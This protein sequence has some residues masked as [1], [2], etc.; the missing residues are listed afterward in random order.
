MSEAWKNGS[1]S[2]WRKHRLTILKRDRWLCTV[3]LPGCTTQ[4]DQVDH[5]QPL[6]KG[7]ARYDPHNC[8]AACAHCNRKRGNSAPLTQPRARPTSSW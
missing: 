8:R 2:R 1:D 3:H 7:G 6:S 4:A 5:I